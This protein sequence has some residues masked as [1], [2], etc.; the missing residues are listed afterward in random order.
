MQNIIV[1]KSTCDFLWSYARLRWIKVGNYTFNKWVCWGVHFF[2][3]YVKLMILELPFNGFGCNRFV[4]KYHLNHLSLHIFFFSSLYNF[5][6]IN[7]LLLKNI[8]NITNNFNFT[9]SILMIHQPPNNFFFF[10]FGELYIEYLKR[11]LTHTW[12]MILLHT[13]TQ[14]ER[15][16]PTSIDTNR[17]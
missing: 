4:T 12:C 17:S 16:M 5:F 9:G 3:F 2:F 14:S 15:E 11:L 13:H 10:F 1:L 8:I 7:P 6:V